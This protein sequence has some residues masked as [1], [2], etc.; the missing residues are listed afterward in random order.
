MN[1]V[2]DKRKS[3]KEA[4]VILERYRKYRR[5]LESDK[6]YG[7]NLNGEGLIDGK[8]REEAVLLV[9]RVGHA[10]AGLTEIQGK[11][12]EEKYIVGHGGEFDYI[13]KDKIQVAERTYYRIKDEALMGLVS[14]LG[15]EVFKE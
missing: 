4:E 13:V 2:V 15:L 9:K 7:V 3:K 12:I 10:I 11:L 5:I 6:L 14:S 8:E 1:I